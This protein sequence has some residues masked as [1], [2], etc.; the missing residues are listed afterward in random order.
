MEDWISLICVKN[1][2]YDGN[3]CHIGDKYYAKLLYGVERY[4]NVYIDKNR[5]FAGNSC[6][7]IE[8]EYFITLAEWRELQINKIIND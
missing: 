2:E 3:R 8:R 6:G 1:Y 7:Y 4:Y 5:S